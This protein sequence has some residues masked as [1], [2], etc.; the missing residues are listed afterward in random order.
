MNQL[1]TV[2]QRVLAVSAQNLEGKVRRYL[3]GGGQG[4]VYEVDLAGQKAALKWYFPE[5]G[6]RTQ[7]EILLAL[8]KQGS[9]D[10]RFLWPIHLAEIPGAPGLGYLMPLRPD[11][12]CGLIKVVLREQRPGFRALLTAGINLTEGFLKL[13]ARGLSYGDISFGNLFLDPKTGEALICDNDNVIVVG[14][15][16]TGILGTPDFM[17]PEIVRGEARPNVE[18]DLHALAVLL[19]YLFFNSHP[20][21]GARMLQIHCLDAAARARLCGTEPLFL[22]DPRDASN[23]ALSFAEDPTGEAGGNASLCWPL[24]PAFFRDLFLQA[25]TAG[26]KTP[27]ARVRESVWRKALSQLRDLLVR[28][29]TGAANFFDPAGGPSQRCWKSGQ[30]LQ[31][32]TLLRLNL[33]GDPKLVALETG[34]ELFPHHLAGRERDYDF[35]T[36][37][38]RVIAHPQHPTLRGLENLTEHPWTATMPDGTSAQVPQG[39]RLSIGPGIKIHFGAVSGETT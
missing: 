24:F 22:F 30:P 14:S 29:P 6:T 17:A 18:T 13:H 15:R 5:Q 9:P 37:L 11:R 27:G 8:V 1:L 35:S 16:S 21:Y 25:F 28:G 3:G 20:L 33:Q 36:P 19:F 26:L 39:K 4:E 2:G 23:R 34:T 38:A 31:P 10:G 12:F 7:R 32:P